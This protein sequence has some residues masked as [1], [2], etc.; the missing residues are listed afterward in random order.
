MSKGKMH[1]NNKLFT[2]V[3]SNKT[4]TQKQDQHDLSLTARNAEIASDIIHEKK[5]K[6]LFTYYVKCQTS[7]YV[8]S[9]SGPTFYTNCLH[10][11]F[12]QQSN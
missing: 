1:E 11:F 6:V 5:E 7:M 8:L 9:L 2:R 4:H 10:F 3:H 12:V